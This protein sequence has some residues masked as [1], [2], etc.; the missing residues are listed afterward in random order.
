MKN[1]QLPPLG[2]VFLDEAEIIKVS[3][4]DD[5]DN[6]ANVNKKRLFS[7]ADRIS[8][9]EIIERKLKKEPIKQDDDEF[10]AYPFYSQIPTPVL[11]MQDIYTFE[12]GKDALKALKIKLSHN[13][14]KDNQHQDFE[15]IPKLA[16]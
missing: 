14:K 12:K 7:L 16:E 5:I 8:I 1:D 6:D 3:E 2:E 15:S 10:T 9:D 4:N 13:K 11:T